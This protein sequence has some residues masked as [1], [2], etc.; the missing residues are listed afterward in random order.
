MP[1]SS[2]RHILDAL[3]LVLLIAGIG[4]YGFRQWTL[5]RD[6]PAVDDLLETLVS[7]P[8]RESVDD[9]L[10]EPE[11]PPP[12]APEPEPEPEPETVQPIV[13]LTPEQAA[14][15][16]VSVLNGT[17]T[18]GL[19]AGA[20]ARLEAQG[21]PVQTLANADTSDIQE[22]YVAYRR[23]DDEGFA[24]GAAQILGIDSV[25]QTDRTFGAKVVVVLGSDYVPD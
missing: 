25:I 9:I 24:L 4:L 13:S 3:V 6:K 1:Q 16:T 7:L 15:L 12:P 20:G 8:E 23:D 18:Q 11:P 19:A 5:V 22:S 17:L 14:D 2:S 21:W 10:D